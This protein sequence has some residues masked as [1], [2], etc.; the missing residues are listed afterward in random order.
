MKC[1]KTSERLILGSA[2]ERRKNI[3]NS[4]NVAFD[5][6]I[7]NVDEVAHVS[8]PRGAAADNALRKL[9][10]CRA[11]YPG[12][13]IIAADTVIDFE[14]RLVGKPATMDEA[15]RFL[16]MFSGK[17]HTVVTAVAFSVR[18][19][20]PDVRVIESDVSF[21]TLDDVLIRKYFEK[22]DPMDKA[23]AYDIDQS[24]D[25]IIESFE[26]SRTNVMGLPREIVEE[27]LAVN[28]LV[29]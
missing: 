5:I 7:A 17:R 21:K 12:R 6:V 10:W 1:D 2:S 11:R 26:G 4:M 19:S 24:G 13:S 28:K 14:G 29:R 3:L 18:G 22:V 27:W 9:E 20:A 25:V 23:G 16:K 15:A 8:D